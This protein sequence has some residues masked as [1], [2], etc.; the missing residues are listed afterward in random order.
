MT[1]IS[2]IYVKEL[3]ELFFLS[4]RRTIDFFAEYS[5][6]IG[7]TLPKIDEALKKENL[8]PSSGLVTCFHNID[9][10]QLD[11]EVGMV[12]PHQVETKKPLNCTVFPAGLVATTIDLGEYEKQ[13]PTMMALTEWISKNGYQAN[14]G[15]YY[16]YLNDE[17]QSPENYLTQMLIPIVKATDSF[18]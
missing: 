14:G 8:A 11:V 16:H 10:A 4:Y 6:L 1:Q 13:D 2:R 7:E 17:K 15:I 3:P 9:L 5:S 18:N 12:I